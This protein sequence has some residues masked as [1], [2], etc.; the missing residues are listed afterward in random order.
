MN[1]KRIATTALLAFVAASV[2][3]LVTKELR[4][5]E[6]IDAAATAAVP[7]GDDAAAEADEAGS[8]YVVYY[9]HGSYRCATCRK[10][11]AYT[12]EAVRDAFGDDLEGGGV[13]WE[14]V[15]VEEPG[16]VHYAKDFEVTGKAVVVAEVR[17]DEQVRWTKLGRI[18]DL[19]GDKQAYITYVQDEVVS[20]MAS[21][22]G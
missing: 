7:S 17:G 8:R 2:V 11:E 14:P 5:Q 19:V 4:R 20:F 21:E 3:V 16:N 1:A 9:L 18:W 13:A 10:L 22:S 6:A 12:E 15:N